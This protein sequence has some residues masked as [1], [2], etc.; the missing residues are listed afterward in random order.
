METR[1]LKAPLDRDYHIDNPHHHHDHDFD[2]YMT[3]NP[4]A[5]AI[6]SINNDLRNP[7]F[8]YIRA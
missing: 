3:T 7:D 4:T 8:R 1:P 6:T 2:C 5:S